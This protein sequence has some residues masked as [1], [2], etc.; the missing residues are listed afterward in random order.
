MSMKN[1]KVWA[2]LSAVI[3]FSLIATL[4]QNIT[5]LPTLAVSGSRFLLLAITTVS[6]IGTIT[7]TI[8]RHFRKYVSGYFFF[9]IFD[10]LQLCILIGFLVFGEFFQARDY[11]VAGYGYLL[12]CP[13]RL[14]IVFLSK[15][16]AVITQ[17]YREISIALLLVSIEI[18]ALLNIRKR[19]V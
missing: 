10:V 1:N 2:A 3:C 12:Y 6:A 13:H 19:S 14:L 16:I 7:F 5:I 4:L 8:A 18:I 15:G 17:N 11:S 9:A